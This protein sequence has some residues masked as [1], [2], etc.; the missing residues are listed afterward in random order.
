MCLEPS[1]DG[2]DLIGCIP[3]ILADCYHLPFRE[4]IDWG[5]ISISIPSAK[6]AELKVT[7]QRVSNDPRRLS[8][9]RERLWEERHHLTWHVPTQPFDA[10]QSTMLSLWMRRFVVRYD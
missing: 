2:R 4:L 5:D 3:V 9:I 6:I 10:F 7:L 1:A 8:T